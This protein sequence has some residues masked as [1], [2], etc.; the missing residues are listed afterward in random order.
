MRSATQGICPST[1]GIMGPCAC[2]KPRKKMPGASGC[3]TFSSSCG[4]SSFRT[5][6]LGGRKGQHT[7]YPAHI[8]GSHAE[9]YVNLEW[10]LRLHACDPT[11]PHLN[12]G[13][14]DFLIFF[15]LNLAF[16]VTE[17][18]SRSQTCCA[19]DDVHLLCSAI[20]EEHHSIVHSLDAWPHEHL[21]VLDELQDVPCAWADRGVHLHHTV[22]VLCCS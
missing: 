10:S 13:Q 9:R 14:L 15:H 16:T 18:S 8:P 6:T 20:V 21:A 19:D 3:T 12:L 22:E 1:H 4:L 7:L 2:T 11:S 5:S 17:V